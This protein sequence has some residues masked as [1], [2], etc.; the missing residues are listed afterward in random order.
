MFTGALIQYMFYLPFWVVFTNLN[1]TPRLLCDILPN[2]I[3][4]DSIKLSRMNTRV[5]WSKAK[6]PMFR[7]PFQFSSFCEGIH[8]PS[9]LPI[10]RILHW[11]C[12]LFITEQQTKTPDGNCISTNIVPI[13]ILTISAGLKHEQATTQ[14][15]ARGG[16]VVKALP[17]KP[18]DR[19]FD[20]RWCLWNFSLT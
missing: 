7:D 9:K 11:G 3:A 13:S 16:A 12:F 2:F 6:K 19:G 14:R 17:Y 20:S 15:G 4:Q 18:S 10:I 1:N 5:R 8:F